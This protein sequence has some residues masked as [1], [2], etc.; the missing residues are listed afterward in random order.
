[1]NKAGRIFKRDIGRLLRNPVALI[2]TIGVCVI[3][4]LYAWYNIAANWDPYA[5]TAGIKIAVAN[6]DAGVSNQ[7]VGELNAGAEVVD[8]LHDN[9]QLGWTFVDADEARA[10]VE[11][12]DYYAAVIIPADFSENLTSM[13][14]G[15]FTQPTLTYYVNEK[16]NAIAPKVTG[17]GAST[18]QEQ[19]NATFVSTVSGTVVERLKAAGADA[20]ASGDAAVTGLADSV[21]SARTSLQDI[22]SSLSDMQGTVG[23]TKEAVS[24]AKD[25]LTAL[26][27]QLPGL[28]DALTQGDTLLASTRTSARTF[29]TSLAAAL[30]DGGVALGQASVR[31]NTAVGKVSGTIMQA[32]ATVD[33]HLEQTQGAVDDL[34][35]LI[36]R[37]EASPAASLPAVERLVSDLTAAR[38]EMQSVHDAAATQSADITRVASSVAQAS[39]SVNTAVSSGL[40]RISAANATLSTSVLPQI[41]NGLD[42]F[43]DT[44]ADLAGAVSSLGPVIEQAEGILDQL[45]NTLDQA[46]AALSETDG[47]LAALDEALANASTDL[48]A[49]RSS[50][51]RAD[52]EQLLGIDG[53]Q[54]ASLMA[55]PVTLETQA[56]YP[57]ATY[58]SGVAPFYTNLALWVGG[59]V[60]IAIF[61]LEVDRE[62]FVQMTATERY[63]GR[64]LL[65][66][67]LGAVQAVIAC[68]GDLVIGVQCGHPV[69]F[70]LAGIWIS[71]VYVNIIYALS[72]AFKHIGKALGVILVIV[73]IPGSSG[74]YPIEMMPGFFQAIHP[75]LPFTYGINA[76]RETIGG[77]Y[78]MAYVRDL[79]ILGIFLVIA[80]VIGVGLRPLLLNL[81]LLFDRQLATTGVMISERDTPANERLSVRLALRA[82]LDV[83]GFR[84]GLVARATRFEARYPLLIRIGFC[85]VFGLP[86]VLF[87]LTAALDLSVDGKIA[88]LVVWIAAVVLA[89]AYLIVVEYLRQDLNMQ[90]RVT[91]LS[92]EELRAEIRRQAAG[93]PAAQ[94]FGVVTEGPDAPSGQAPRQNG[95]DEA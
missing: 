17:T 85:L 48:T 43:A 92:D 59:F 72:I 30:A 1:M 66:V 70:V 57:V 44:S 5:N 88:M 90:M 41:S 46:S 65:L 29:S 10:G 61:K 25:T 87:V 20:E 22:R 49:L 67:L 91:A 47:S 81:N 89:D 40:D 7:Y 8:E 55:A 4:S 51:A 3:P 54:V 76:M 69:L 94:V 78:G 9:H 35:A 53:D 73:Q 27:G 28:R 37:I 45:S 32:G 15:T 11:R 74:M 13:L 62:G 71:F 68:V 26:N 58:G 34:S 23:A 84:T 86:I 31:A 95:G 42:A 12:G 39:D 56:V 21:S 75:L 19:V 36:A 79:A 14:T 24:S 50:Q 64:W 38:D 52:L 2:V 93:S 77:L 60:L 18:I 82:L 63:F 83:G 33:A 80:L 16:K 6:E